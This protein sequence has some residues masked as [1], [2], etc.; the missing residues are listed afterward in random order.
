MSAEGFSFGYDPYDN[1]NVFMESWFKAT[2]LDGASD[3]HPQ[4]LHALTSDPERQ[5]G[6]RTD[7]APTKR[8]AHYRSFLGVPNDWLLEFARQNK[9]Q[10][11]GQ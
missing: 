3:F 11:E 10:F 6:S 8:Y 1:G 4:Q 9:A 2:Q 7:E 5:A